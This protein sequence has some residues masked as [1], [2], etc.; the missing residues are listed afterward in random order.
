MNTNPARWGK[1]L[2]PLKDLIES[3]PRM[4]AADTAE[5]IHRLSAQIVALVRSGHL[6]QEIDGTLVSDFGYRIEDI[7]ALIV[8]GVRYDVEQF[9]QGFDGPVLIVC[10]HADI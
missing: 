2:F 5:I 7:F 3:R 9:D 1:S 6:G 8:P 10:Q 4:V